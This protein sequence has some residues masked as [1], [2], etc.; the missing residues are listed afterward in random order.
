M[1]VKINYVLM[2]YVDVVVG[3][4]CFDVGWLICVVDV[5]ECIYVV[6]LQI[7]FLCVDWVVWFVFLV[8]VIFFKVGVLGDYFIGWK[9]FWLFL[10]ELDYCF[11]VLGKFGV[12][13][14]DF[15]LDCLVVGLDEVEE[16]FVWIDYDCV[17]RI[18][19]WVIDC[20][21]QIF[22]IEVLVLDVGK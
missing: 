3:S 21:V 5:I 12:F 2:L 16:F 19:V 11:F 6:L 22:G 1:I 18:V 8:V 14:F 15:V 13:N 4:V 10:F 7:E 9:L 17:D 20:L